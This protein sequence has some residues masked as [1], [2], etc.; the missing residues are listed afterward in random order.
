LNNTNPSKEIKKNKSVVKIVVSIIVTVLLG[1]VG[2]GVWEA[3]GKP[4]FNS[5]SILVLNLVSLGSESLNS[6]AYQEAALTPHAQSGLIIWL[7]ILS[8]KIVLTLLAIISVIVLNLQFNKQKIH[9]VMMA[10]SKSKKKWILVY[11][12]ILISFFPIGSQLVDFMVHNQAILIWRVFTANYAIC[13]PYIESHEKEIIL[14]QYCQ[15]KNKK[16]Y[17]V[18]AEKLIL[19]AQKNKLVLINHPLW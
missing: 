15:I 6:R 11:S 2:S 14:S 10:I 18:I 12:V 3:L 19:V 5:L 9:N 16:D 17:T 1:A 8:L 7:E 13:S 4:A